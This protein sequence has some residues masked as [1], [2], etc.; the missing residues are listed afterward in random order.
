M[1]Q[2][3]VLGLRPPL[4]YLNWRSLL[5]ITPEFQLES[6]HLRDYGYSVARGGQ[7]ILGRERSSVP[8]ARC[9]YL[10]LSP[11]LRGDHA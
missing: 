11:H 6:I 10:I 1:P 3:A 5:E 9:Q 7:P 2:L 4:F 8:G